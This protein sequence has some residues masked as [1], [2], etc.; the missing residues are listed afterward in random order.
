MFLGELI[1]EYRKRHQ[2]SMQTFA[3]RADL[4]KA[5]ISQLENNRNPKTGG[6]IIPSAETFVKVAAAMNMSADELYALV[7]E[8]QPL[9][10]NPVS[11]DSIRGLDTLFETPEEHVDRLIDE[12]ADI[13]GLGSDDLRRAINFAL[14]I[15]GKD[16]LND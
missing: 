7:D 10:I 9:L 6:S 4:S 8:N 13:V 11:S 14:D 3:D 1:K 2:I 15:K 12:L 16:N 5:Y